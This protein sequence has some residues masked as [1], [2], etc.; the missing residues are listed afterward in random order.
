MVF[1]CLPTQKL[2]RNVLF[3]KGT[4][5]IGKM[6][7]VWGNFVFGRAERVFG[8]MFWVLISAKQQVYWVIK[9]RF[10]CLFLER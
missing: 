5:N 10:S 2:Q 1:C 8:I 7:P 3:N 6:Q 9:H 4:S